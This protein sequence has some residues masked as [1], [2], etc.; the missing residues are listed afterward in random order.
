MEFKLD[1]FLD[2]LEYLVNTESGSMDIEG[3][4]KIADF[5]KK[6]LKVLTL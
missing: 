5:L 6:S 2:E 1:V 3:L 4:N